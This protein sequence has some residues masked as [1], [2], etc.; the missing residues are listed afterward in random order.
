[1]FSIIAPMDT[2]RLE[3]FKVTKQIYDS[4]PEKKE[5]I[6][7]TR[8]HDRIRDYLEDNGLTKDVTLIPYKHKAGFNPSL[9]LNIG[10]KRAKYSN[11]IITSPEVKP[12]TRVLEQ[13]SAKLDKNVVCQ[14][15][16]ADSEGKLTSLVNTTYRSDT[17]AMYF[18]AM[19]KKADIEAINGWDEDFM[20]GY[21]YEDND[22]GDRWVRAGLPFEVR[23]EIQAIHQYHE[24]LET[25][26]NGSSIN[27]EKMCW[28]KDNN[29]IRPR[30]GLIKLADL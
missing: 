22:F 14:V 29:V 11:L 30:N 1:M 16:D 4:F 3:Q 23:D 10:V 18:L 24:R 15:Y 6:I 28:N 17:P 20:L 9:P 2:N 27:F 12:K 21:A 13:L 5:F 25:I 26:R 19:F 7:P 8:S